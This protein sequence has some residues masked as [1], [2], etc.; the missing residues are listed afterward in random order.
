MR[1]KKQERETAEEYAGLHWNESQG[2][3]VV[4]FSIAHLVS[5]SVE[6]IMYV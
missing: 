3:M 5:W 1:R 6:E 4:V 2:Q